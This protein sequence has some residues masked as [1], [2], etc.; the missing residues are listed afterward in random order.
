MSAAA[1]VHNYPGRRA[2][3]WFWWEFKP[4]DERFMSIVNGFVV[5]GG[6]YCYDYRH[7]DDWWTAETFIKH[8]GAFSYA[9]CVYE[10]FVQKAAGG[11][12][13]KS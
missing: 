12:G 9:M 13:R 4:A 6:R 1:F 3:S 2:K 10:D 7:M 11:F 8:D 5:T